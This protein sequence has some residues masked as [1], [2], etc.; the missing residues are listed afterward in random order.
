VEEISINNG[1]API[2]T[3]KGIA[4][5]TS[6][7]RA[8]YGITIKM[9]P[10]IHISDALEES[11]CGKG[12]VTLQTDVS[13]DTTRK[14]HH[15]DQPLV[16]RRHI[17][18]EVRVPDGQTIILGGL[19][20]KASHDEEEK[21]PFLGDIP[22]IG[23]L[24]GSVKL[25]NNNTEMFIFITPTIVIDPEEQLIQ[26][27]ME[28]VK[29]RPGDIPEYLQRVVEAQEKEARRQFR[30]SFKALFGNSNV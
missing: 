20:R 8:Q 12:F 14:H 16:D 24:F 21:V 26:I 23:K 27:R 29:K 30:N 17:E 25:T 6:F 5:E 11:A 1:A 3:N 22:G 7:T 4:F 13:F 15:D 9:T 2:D 10:T 19:R 18:N 28:E